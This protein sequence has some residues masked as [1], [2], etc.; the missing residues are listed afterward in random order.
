MARQWAFV[1]KLFPFTKKR[2]LQNIIWLIVHGY[3]S[4]KMV[5]QAVFSKTLWSRIIFEY[6]NLKS[7]IWGKINRARR[8][9]HKEMF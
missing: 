7:I 2:I 5:R 4:E 8:L 6:F 1:P 9:M 3:A